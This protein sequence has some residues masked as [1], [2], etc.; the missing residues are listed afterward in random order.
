M[1]SLQGLIDTESEKNRLNKELSNI[2]NEIDQISKRLNNQM[3]ID[4]APSNVVQEVKNKQE[5]FYQRKSEIEKAL[6]NL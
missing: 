6:I 5:I 2:N 1:I 4:K 3:F